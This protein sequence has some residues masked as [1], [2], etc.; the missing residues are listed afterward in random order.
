[1]PDPYFDPFRVKLIE[2]SDPLAQAALEIHRRY[3]GHKPIRY[4]DLMFGGTSVEELYLY[5]SL[6]PVISV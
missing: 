4:Q 1:M 5:P 3:P 2:T 6:Q